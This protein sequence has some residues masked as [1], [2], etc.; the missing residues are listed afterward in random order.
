MST[1]PFRVSRAIV[2]ATGITQAAAT[3]APAAR[4]RLFGSISFI[5]L[6]ATGGVLLAVGIVIAMLA[7]QARTRWAAVCGILSLLSLLMT[8]AV[9]QRLLTR[10]LTTFADPLVRRMM[11]PAWGLSVIALSALIG[12]VAAVWD[13]K[14]DRR[15]R[16]IM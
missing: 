16:T 9:Y 4:V 11:H 10:P 1:S 6:H 15:E 8:A 12:T 14:A 3:F 2:A 13:L 5:R 7:I